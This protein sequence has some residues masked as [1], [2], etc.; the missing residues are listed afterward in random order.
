ML[1]LSTPEY[2]VRRMVSA[3]SSAIESSVFLNSSKPIGSRSSRASGHGSDLHHDV[4]RGVE[5]RAGARRHHAG[6]VVLLDHRGALAAAWRDRRGRGSASRASRACGPKYTRRTDGAGEAPRRAVDPDRSGPRARDRRDPLA[7]HA[8]AHDLDRLVGAGAM[9]V[10]PL[11]LLAERLARA[12]SGSRPSAPARSAR[13]TG[14]GSAVG[15]ARDAHRG[16][17]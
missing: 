8:Q 6:R 1:S 15:R 11:V 10:G 3:I 4:A 16:R 17:R 9:A 14:P 12:A 7:D 13:T 5:L 2:A